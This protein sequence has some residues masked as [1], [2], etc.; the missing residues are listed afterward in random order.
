MLTSI[1]IIFSFSVVF[2]ASLIIYL[3]LILLSILIVKQCQYFLKKF[4]RI[5]ENKIDSPFLPCIIGHYLSTSIVDTNYID[6]IRY[7]NTQLF[8]YVSNIDYIRYINK[9]LCVKLRL[10][11]MR[12][13]RKKNV[14]YRVITK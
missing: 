7:I 5:S 12:V 10:Q 9:Q 4:Y 14:N 13:I 11:Y 2:L 3:L 1:F 6:Y 8:V